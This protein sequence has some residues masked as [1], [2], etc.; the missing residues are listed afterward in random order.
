MLAAT[1]NSLCGFMEYGLA[2]APMFE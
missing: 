2:K 1:R